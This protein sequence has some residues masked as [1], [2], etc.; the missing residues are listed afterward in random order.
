MNSAQVPS[1]GQAHLYHPEIL[2]HAR[3]RRR[4]VVSDSV[5]RLMAELAYGGRP[6]SFGTWIALGDVTAQAFT[7]HVGGT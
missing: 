4:V 6:E 2:C 5:A 1:A 7:N 3:I